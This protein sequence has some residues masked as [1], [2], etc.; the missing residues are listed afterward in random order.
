MAPL[1]A[2]TSSRQRHR[3]RGRHVLC[4]GLGALLSPQRLAAC[5]G[6]VAVQG[7]LGELDRALELSPLI[8]SVECSLYVALSFLITQFS[9]LL[10]LRARSLLYM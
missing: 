5:V 4:V 2:Q 6:L 10:A 3:V 8:V 7:R 1:T 9:K